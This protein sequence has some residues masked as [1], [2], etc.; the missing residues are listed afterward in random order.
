M[1]VYRTFASKRITLKRLIYSLVSFFFSL[2]HFGHLSH[3]IKACPDKIHW[4]VL[5]NIVTKLFQKNSVCD[6]KKAAWVARLRSD[7][8]WPN[9]TDYT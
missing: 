3:C 1:V 6:R 9:F 4:S 2:R 7:A 8:H 5:S